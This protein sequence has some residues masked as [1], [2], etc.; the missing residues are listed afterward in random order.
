MY[1]LPRRLHVTVYLVLGAEVSRCL[2][3]FRAGSPCD[4]KRGGL[5]IPRPRDGCLC[6]PL[7]GVHIRSDEGSF[8]GVF[9]PCSVVVLCHG[10]QWRVLRLARPLTGDGPQFWRRG[11]T[12]GSITYL[13]ISSYCFSIFIPIFDIFT[14]TVSIFVSF[15]LLCTCM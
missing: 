10:G 15:I 7:A 1:I 3:F 4:F 6:S 11:R 5:C 13:I 12:V 14:A 2:T 8:Q 9:I